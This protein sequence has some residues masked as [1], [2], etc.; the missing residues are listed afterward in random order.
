[1]SGIGSTFDSGPNGGTSPNLSEIS[2]ALSLSLFQA[3]KPSCIELSQI[4][5]LPEP[6]FKTQILRLSSLLESTHRVLENHY[7]ENSNSGVPY[8]LSPNVADYIFFPLSQIL[9]QPE[10]DDRVATHL[11][12]IIAF[13]VSHIWSYDVDLRFMDELLPIVLFLTGSGTGSK[14]KVDLTSKTLEFKAAAI[15][16]VES[17]VHILPHTY[18]SNEESRRLASLGST[19]TLLLEVLTSGINPSSQEA[20]ELLIKDLVLLILLCQRKVSAEQLTHILPGIVSSVVNYFSISK[21]LHFTV[22]LKLIETLRVIITKVFKDSDLSTQF[23]EIEVLENIEDINALWNQET[24]SDKERDFNNNTAPLVRIEIPSGSGPR[25]TPWLAATSKQVKL[26][27]VVFFKLLL[28]TS[29]NNKLK[30]QTKDRL[31]SAIYDFSVS[32]FQYSFLTL[33]NEVIPLALDVIAMTISLTSIDDEEEQRAIFD[34]SSRVLSTASMSEISNCKLLFK[35][36]KS[37]LDD[38]IDNKLPSIV[39]SLDDD[40][41][42]T[43]LICLK[44][45]LR[46][47][48]DLAH[49]TENGDEIV[50]QSKQ[51]L[52]LL[53]EKSLTESYK[54]NKEKKIDSSVLSVLSGNASSEV[55]PNKLDNVELPPYINAMKV[56]KSHNETTVEQISDTYSSNLVLIADSWSLS[57]IN[58]ADIERYFPNMFSKTIEQKF[59]SFVQFLASLADSSRNNDQLQL[60]ETILEQSLYSEKNLSTLQRGIG[61]WIANNYFKEQE[62]QNDNIDLDEYLVLSDN[63]S[64]HDEENE[65]EEMSYLLMSKSQD[66]INEVS[67]AISNLQ[68]SREGLKVYEMSYSIAIDSIGILS[69][70]IPLQDFRD[71]FLIEYLYPLLEALTFRANPLIQSHAQAALHQILENYY[72]GSFESL[73]LDNSDY[74]IDSI[75]LKLS[76]PSNLVPTLP[77]I[78]LIIIKVAGIN[79]LESNQL[80][81]IL[82]EMFVIIDSY[83]GYSIIVEGLFIVFEELM[84]QVRDRYLASGSTNYL[85]SGS[86]KNTSSYRPWGISN[87]EQLLKLLDD[88]EKLIEPPTETYDSTKEY[89]QRK[90]NT[91][92]SEQA[93]DSDDE[94]EQE[95]NSEQEDSWPSEVP[96]NTYFLVQRIFK[97]G[98]VLLTQKSHSLKVQILRTLRQTYPILCSNYKLLLVTLTSNWPIL[99]SLI[100]GSTSLS[101]FETSDLSSD[102]ENLMIPS[103]EFAIDILTQDASQ[104]EKFLSSK[105]IESWNF[106]VDHSPIFKHAKSA[107]IAFSNEKQIVRSTQEIT[108]RRL[109]PRISKLLV[110]YIITGVNSYERSV[111]DLVRYDMVKVCYRM[112]IPSDLELNTDIKKDLW[113]IQHQEN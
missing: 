58:S 23:K 6:A 46:L 26:S 43:Y 79:L 49:H 61:L 54:F 12:N 36:V 97:Y 78:L 62:A 76:V 86:S 52:L 22:I 98:F 3:V 33:L 102:Q 84:K 110:K 94:E 64:L 65:V 2:R 80:N 18:F 45:H 16:S 39:L 83:H 24:D 8:Q 75:S 71:N 101:T 99:L 41:I 70:K 63:E 89:F 82:T 48:F 87:V 104:N 35:S 44:F 112:G 40:K 109:N 11:L 38:L 56:G 25:T 14:K 72:G 108:A 27:L 60:M 66:L 106:F 21:N 50:F 96:K 31:A 90:P 34:G 59:T 91:P 17:I 69:N 85:E 93:G 10:L 1:M 100:S 5:L 81:D 51:R 19:V 29:N 92:F 111:S 20:N 74:L 53:L 67:E 15:S 7:K 77:G 9:K 30:V 95:E 47:L 88:S 73:I 37:K 55:T 68:L 28:V 42:N 4:G 107:K 32:I 57:S 103:L 113:V 105:F 13:L